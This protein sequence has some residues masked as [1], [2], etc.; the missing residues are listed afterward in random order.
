VEGRSVQKRL[1]TAEVLRLLD[2]PEFDDAA[3]VSK[4]PHD[5]YR[6][7]AT[8]KEF[9]KAALG[10]VSRS[11]IDKQ[12]FRTRKLYEKLMEEQSQREKP[13]DKPVTS[14]RYWTAIFLRVAAIVLIC[15]ALYLGVSLL[16]STIRSL[17]G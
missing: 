10:R 4:T 3:K 6:A 17:F 9:E 13:P 5:G 2:L 1:T 8:F 15:G 14:L 16:I 12:T 11:G 7:L